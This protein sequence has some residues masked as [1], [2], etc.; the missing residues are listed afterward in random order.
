M[1]DQI[2]EEKFDPI[3]RAE[4]KQKSRDQDA[5]DLRTGKKN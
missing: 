4:E 3:K 2:K 5:E 1:N